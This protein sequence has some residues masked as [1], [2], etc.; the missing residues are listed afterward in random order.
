[1]SSHLLSYPFRNL[2]THLRFQVAIESGSSTIS[3]SESYTLRVS[4]KQG[5]PGRYEDRLE[6]S[7]QDTILKQRFIITRTLKAIVGDKELFHE[8]TPKSPYIPPQQG[9]KKEIG[10]FIGGVKPAAL[11]AVQYKVKLQE[12]AI[13]KHLHDLLSSPEPIVRITKQIKDIFFPVPLSN[14]NY[15]IFFKRLLWVEE[16]KMEYVQ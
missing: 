10:E 9:A 4:F 13:P 11:K 16:M 3:A 14:F 5:Y 1:V 7:F 15:G 2:L 8:L 6:F 12:A